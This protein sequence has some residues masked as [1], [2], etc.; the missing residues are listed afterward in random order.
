MA[1]KIK[2]TN[3]E[4]RIPPARITD[5]DN[6]NV[7]E[8]D[9]N[10][11]S[12]RFAEARKFKVEEVVDYPSTNLPLLFY[13]AFRM[14]HSNVAKSRVDAIYER[15]GGLSP[16]FIE[17]LILLYQQ[18]QQSNNVVESDEEMGKNGNLTV[19]L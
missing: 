7:Y 18:A 14:H 3:V 19:E 11:D 9:F 8:L 1:S 10:R 13:Y 17:R 4:E 16:N 15:L 5:E 2:E 6:G 12:V